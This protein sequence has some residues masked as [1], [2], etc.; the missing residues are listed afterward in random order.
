M[1]DHDNL[2]F[3]KILKCFLFF[4]LFTGTLGIGILGTLGIRI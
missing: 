4:R 3:Y 2:T 1:S